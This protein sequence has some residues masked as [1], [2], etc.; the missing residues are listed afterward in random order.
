MRRFLLGRLA[1]RTV[2]AAL[3]IPLQF[4][5]AAHAITPE[6]GIYWAPSRPSNL[7]VIENQRGKIAFIAYTYDE[8]GRAEWFTSSGVLVPL[9][10]GDEFPAD[11]WQ[12]DAPLSR[13]VG[14]PP[15]GT[16]GRMPGDPLPYPTIAPIGR[17]LLTFYAESQVDLEIR[18]NDQTIVDTLEPFNFGYGSIGQS[19][20]IPWE[21]CW[22]N[23][24]GEWVFV[25]RTEPTRPAW[26]FRFAEPQA[27]VWDDAGQPTSAPMKCGDTQQ[28]HLITFDD[29]DSG[30]YLRCALQN[31]S[32]RPS[33]Y[34]AHAEGCEL[35]SE[36]GTVLFS[37]FLFAYADQLKRIRAW[38][39]AS[40]D[41]PPG[42]IY[43]DPAG[44]PI[45]GY[46]VE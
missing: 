4:A 9:P 14:G 34:P 6:S 23:Y 28:A 35:V 29:L 31:S 32:A 37:F 3:F 10:A 46:R 19:D 2:L 20:Q 24:S 25:D 5:T 22:K 38:H 40:R 43:D 41:V 8:Q 7:Y 36:D 42:D 18:I 12:L 13:A 21:H 26:R 11:R 16:P 30:A 33:D 45:T 17:V 27:R 39:G 44:P 1:S 15:L